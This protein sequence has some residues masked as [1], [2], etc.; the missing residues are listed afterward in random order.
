MD[1]QRRAPN[2]QPGKGSRRISLTAL[3]YKL[4]R[5]F[6]IVGVEAKVAAVAA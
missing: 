3:A 5:A 4:R 2:A 1:E 6:N